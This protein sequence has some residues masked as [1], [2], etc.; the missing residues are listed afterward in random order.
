MYSAGLMP[1]KPAGLY[2]ASGQASDPAQAWPGSPRA[3]QILSESWPDGFVPFEKLPHTFNPPEGFVESCN[4]K[5]TPDHYPVFYDWNFETPYRGMRI[6]ELLSAERKISIEDMKAAQLDVHSVVARQLT[7][8]IL[9]AFENANEINPLVTAGLDSLRP[10]DFDFHVSGVAPTIYHAFWENFRQEI[11]AKH[12]RPQDGPS[13]MNPPRRILMQLVREQPNSKW[14]DD[15]Q[16]APV[17]NLHDR[18]REIFSVSLTSLQTE[19]G[20]D[21]SQWKYGRY[22]TVRAEHILRLQDFGAGPLPRDGEDHTLNV[23]GGREVEHGPSMRL[24]VEMGNPIRGYI[25]NFGGQSGHPGAPHYQDQIDEWL[26][27][28]YFPIR[29]SA[30]PNAFSKEE[31][32]ETVNLKP[33]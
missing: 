25:V 24:V 6:H 20:A 17:E 33:R 32:E 16:T 18:V 28:N 21:M 30:N 29:F 14:F 11:W 3:D 12:F 5:P 13:Y 4:Q 7:P 19:F 31:I 15:P 9:R 22:H 8:I 10:W 1:I 27:G 2:Q 26:A 23:A